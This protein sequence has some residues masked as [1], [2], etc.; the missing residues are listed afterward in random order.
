MFEK[1]S[2]MKLRFA[3]SRGNITTEDLWDLPLPSLDTLAQQCQ[4]E[5]KDDTTSFIK[6]VQPTNT[7]AKLRFEVVKRV[8]DVR[9][10]EIEAADNAAIVKGKKQQILAIMADKESESLKGASMEDLQKML[11]DL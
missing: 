5:A 11:E 3:T 10:A 4:K 9:L 2:K 1:A 8:I 7:V 6:K